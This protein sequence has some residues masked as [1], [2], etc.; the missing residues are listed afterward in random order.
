MA[1]VQP[2]AVLEQLRWR[3]ATKKFDPSKKIAPAIWRSIEEA[4][5]LAPSGYGLQ[6]WKFIVIETPALRAKLREASYNQPQITDASH[7]VVFC[8]KIAVDEPHIDRYIAQIVKTRG[9]SAESLAGFRS[10]M[11][12]SMTA[13]A[14]KPDAAMDSLT[15]AQTYIALGFGLAAAAM[16]GVDACPMEGFD[17]AKYDEILGLR[18][19][20]FKASVVGTF[21]YRAHDDVVDPVRAAKVR[22]AHEEVVEHR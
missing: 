16:M 3:Y 12:G 21:G 9:V 22:F 2:Q 15:R 1:T 14:A 11:L 5:V 7:M 19:Q 13:I 20:G 4:I 8:R 18:E 17:P 10:A 6:P